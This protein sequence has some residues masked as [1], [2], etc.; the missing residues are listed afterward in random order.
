MDEINT[1]YLFYCSGS[2][3]LCRFK[4]LLLEHLFLN[5]EKA[6][7]SRID[8]D[9]FSEFLIYLA[10]HLDPVIKRYNSSVSDFTNY[11]FGV[12]RSSFF[13]WYRKYRSQLDN[14]YY[15]AAVGG[16]DIDE[17]EYEYKCSEKSNEIETNEKLLSV[18]D[19]KK[20]TEAKIGAS[21]KDVL[22]HKRIS[23]VSDSNTE[24]LRNEACLVLAVK[25]CFFIDDEMIEKLS[26]IT[27]IPFDEIL[28]LV[29]QAKSSMNRKIFNKKELERKR[30]FAY[31]QKKKSELCAAGRRNYFWDVYF[32]DEKSRFHDRKWLQ[33]L[34][35]LK[36][37]NLK[38]VPSNNVVG[39]ILGID[40]RRVSYIV[41]IAQKNLESIKLVSEKKAEDL[42]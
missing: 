22:K 31:F 27:G 12:L 28:D 29:N 6:G 14:N 42:C 18:E 10:E 30:N 17:R 32:L 19:L 35:K 36:T 9:C 15:L 16:E 20:I 21:Y 11:F 1:N 39:M 41:K 4:N 38:M 3:D 24:V 8:D 7:L 2:I 37:C 26:V 13:W 40:C 23:N 5:R 33:I 25:S 34:E